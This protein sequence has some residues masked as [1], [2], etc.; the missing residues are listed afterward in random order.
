MRKKW[1]SEK[2]GTEGCTIR[3][4]NATRELKDLPVDIFQLM[5]VRDAFAETVGFA[6]SR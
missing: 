4:V 6:Q 1:F 3:G 2:G 5:S